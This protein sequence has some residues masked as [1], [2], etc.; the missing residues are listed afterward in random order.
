MFFLQRVT[1]VLTFIFVTWHVWDTRVQVALGN[2]D[3]T[4]FGARLHELVSNPV[5][6]AL[7]IIGLV[8]ASFHFS[9]GMWAFL[10]SWGIT[11]GP[12]AQRVSSYIWMGVFVIMSVMFILA[13]SAFRNEEFALLE[14]TV[15]SI[16]G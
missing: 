8:A 14:N 1:G 10:V 15:R 11:V 4:D 6:Y 5:L 16:I 12:R 7:Y 9:N 2:I 13:I 3:H